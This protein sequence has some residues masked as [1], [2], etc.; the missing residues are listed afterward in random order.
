MTRR[1]TFL[2]SFVLLV[3]ACAS[4]V[5]PS[6]AT[7]S[8]SPPVATAP[9]PTATP[10]A[11]ASVVS[12]ALRLLVLGDSIA[13]PEMGCGSCEGF[14]QQYA[15]Y[16]ETLTGRP[17]TLQNEARPNARIEDLQALL[18]TDRAVQEAVA[19]ADIV[20]VSIGYNDTPPWAPE[21]PCH[22]PEAK[23]DADLWA[24][25]LAMTPDCIDATVAIYQERLDA[26]YGRVEELAAGRPQVR[27]N[28][29]SF[30]NLKDNP[31]GDGTLLTAEPDAMAAAYIVFQSAMDAWN[32]ADCEAAT[33]HG[34]VCGDIHHA[35]N[36]PDGTKSIK[37]LVN[38]ADFVHPSVAGQAVIAEL[39][40]RVDVSSLAGN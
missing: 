23:K 8:S 15:T 19:Q 32:K 13:I 25:I 14:D 28:L 2:A 40:E 17:V 9:A 5:T 12:N 29:G 21:M 34:F 4:P 35:F 30:D 27:I 33:G 11:S 22:T 39:L 18:D 37:G 24:L 10:Q 38:P 6:A 36:G 7:G 20:V 26:L 16:L 3:T 1:P 31:G